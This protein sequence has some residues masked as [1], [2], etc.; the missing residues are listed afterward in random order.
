MGHDFLD[1]AIEKEASDIHITENK[2][3]LYRILGEL[4]KLID[5][6]MGSVDIERFIKEYVDD[7]FSIE[8]LN[9]DGYDFSFS[10]DNRRFRG[11][12]FRGLNGVSLSIRLLNSKI[13]TIEEMGLPLTLYDIAKLNDGL[14]LVTGPTGSGKSTT[15]AAIVE[16]INRN[17]GVN[18]IT[19]EDPIEYIYKE[20]KARI[21]QREV[22]THVRSFSSAVKESLRQDPDVVLV[23]ELRDLDTIDNALILAETGHLVLGT[24]HA[25][26]TVEAIDR[27]IGVFPESK[28]KEVQSE[29]VSVIQGI[30][31]QRLI[32]TQNFKM[33]PLCEIM[34]FSDSIRTMVK[35]KE[36]R[37]KN[38]FRDTIRS[39]KDKGSIHIADYS[40]KLYRKGLIS[41]EELKKVLDPEDFKFFCTINDLR[42]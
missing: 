5:L 42:I 40:T 9:L 39:D 37:N 30:M 19:I 22:G 2:I 21:E 10:Y 7:S 24:L 34:M 15:M 38:N 13:A 4:V 25:K 33:T 29:L 16:E 28:Q 36:K 23:G 11:H 3:I 27:I 1:L 14:F 32:K 18:I 20:K 35:E 26:S 12:A 17:R 41:L 6:V 8:N 31:Y